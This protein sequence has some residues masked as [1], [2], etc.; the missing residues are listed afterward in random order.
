MKPA[1]ISL[2]LQGFPCYNKQSSQQQRS[3]KKICHDIFRVYRDTEF[4]LSNAR[5]QDYVATKK[6]SVATTNHATIKN[7]IAIK[8]SI[9]AIKIEENHKIKSQHRKECCNKVKE[10]EAKSSVATEDEE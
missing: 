2:L 1:K 7:V 4:C 9:I 5:Q 8:E 6:K 3:K 10:L